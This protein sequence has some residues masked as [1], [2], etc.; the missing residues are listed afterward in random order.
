MPGYFLPGGLLDI[1][2]GIEDIAATWSKNLE[3]LE[4]FPPHLVRCTKG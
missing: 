1:M 2:D 4:H 3:P